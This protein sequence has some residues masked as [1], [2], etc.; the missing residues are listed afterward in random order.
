MQHG[1]PF[2]QSQ[3][4]RAELWKDTP[5]RNTCIC[6][7]TKNAQSYKKP[8]GF[9]QLEHQCQRT[10][11]RVKSHAIIRSRC[12]REKTCTIPDRLSKLRT[13]N[14][15]NAK[16]RCN[17]VMAVWCMRIIAAVDYDSRNQLDWIGRP[18]MD[19]GVSWN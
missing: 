5:T 7:H 9:D 15:K 19:P 14:A 8:Y 4:N 12:R 1:I 13:R 18:P 2:I 6:T 11:P 16:R 17:E 10:R 3:A